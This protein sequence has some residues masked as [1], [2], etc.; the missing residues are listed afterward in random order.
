MG[1]MLI[2]NHEPIFSLGNDISLRNLP[3]S[4]SQRK[5]PT[6]WRRCRSGF[7]ASRWMWRFKTGAGAAKTTTDRWRGGPGCGNGGD[8]DER[9][10][11]GYGFL[12][13]GREWIGVRG[14]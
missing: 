5:T 9:S 6:P 7:G 10:W 11:G 12:Q 2:H 3:A 8:W 4:H 14:G 1:C 13:A